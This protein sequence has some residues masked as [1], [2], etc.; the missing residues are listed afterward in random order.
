MAYKIKLR[1][2]R[3]PPAGNLDNDIDFI[4]RSFGYFTKRDKN[5]TAGRIFQ[6]VIKKT[7]ED[8]EGVTSDEIANELDLT[9]GAIVYH[10]NNFISA[11]L[12]VRERNLYRLRSHCLKKSIDEIRNDAQRIFTEMMEIA[13]E[14]D[15]E[16]GIFYR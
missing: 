6:Y 16:L 1:R 3:V 5:N 11:G 13:E 7:A 2:L 9:R 14:I 12:I 8:A 15:E 4:C 10:L